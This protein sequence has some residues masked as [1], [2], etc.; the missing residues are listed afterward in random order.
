LLGA[1]FF[2][3]LARLILVVD[4]V[5]IQVTH[6]V[7]VLL[8]EV[9]SLA[10]VLAPNYLGMLTAHPV[11]CVLQVRKIY[12]TGLA[13]AFLRT[14]I[15]A[16]PL[17]DVLIALVKLVP[18]EFQDRSLIHLIFA[19]DLIDVF[20]A[21]RLLAGHRLLDD[22]TFIL[23]LVFIIELLSHVRAVRIFLAGLIHIFLLFHHDCILPSISREGLELVL[24]SVFH[25]TL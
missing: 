8:D 9:F 15:S 6:I 3:I 7:D 11:C 19:L 16:I 20:E 10:I 23:G 4:K 24:K 14:N 25:A 13:V 5:L 12:R 21:F 18:I 2:F 17:V 1:V 22:D